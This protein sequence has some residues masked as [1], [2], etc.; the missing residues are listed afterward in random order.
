MYWKVYF[1]EKAAKQAR[2]LNKRVIS[3]L[4]LLVSD[5][6]NKGGAPGKGWPHYGKLKGKKIDIR[7]CHLIRGKPTYVCCWEVKDKLKEIE[8][9]YVGTHENAPY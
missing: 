3:I 9:N 2:K 4:D 6:R 5:L 1:S 8:V 7:H